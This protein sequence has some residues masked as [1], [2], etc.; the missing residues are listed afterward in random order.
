ME[1]KIKQTRETSEQLKGLTEE[2]RERPSMR[3]FTHLALFFFTAQTIPIEAHE[4]PFLK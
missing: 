1:K 4:T 2:Q 3:Y